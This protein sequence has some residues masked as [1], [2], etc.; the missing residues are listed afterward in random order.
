MIFAHKNCKRSDSF[1]VFNSLFRYQPRF[2]K[3]EIHL[4]DQIRVSE[5]YISHFKPHLTGKFLPR[6]HKIRRILRPR[7]ILVQKHPCCLLVILCVNDRQQVLIHAETA[8]TLL[9]WPIL[10]K[11][12]AQT[13]IANA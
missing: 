9:F 6:Q 13:L 4:S 1:R 8:V 2:C 3:I 10:F 12:Y 5:A 11:T 7:E